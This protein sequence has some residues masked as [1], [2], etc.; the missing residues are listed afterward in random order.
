MMEDLREALEFLNDQSLKT[1]EAY[2]HEIEGDTYCFYNGMMQL[3]QKK[4]DQCS[5]LDVYSLDMLVKMIKRELQEDHDFPL[6]V[7]VEDNKNVIVYGSLNKYKQREVILSAIAEI[8]Y[9]KFG[10]FISPEEMIIYLMTSF[11]H[12][13]NIDKLTE[14][15]S[16][17]VVDQTVEVKDDGFSQTVTTTDGAQLKHAVSISPLAKLQPVRTFTETDQPEQM[18]LV[19]VDKIGQV[20]LIDASAGS[21]KLECMKSVSKFLQENLSEEIETGQVIVG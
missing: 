18:F 13:E 12:T 17:I 14:L 8:P 19:R 10:K 11:I 20:A 5:T 21:Y 7:S 15:L 4:I 9:E 16:S 6:I 1:V 3:V 2:T